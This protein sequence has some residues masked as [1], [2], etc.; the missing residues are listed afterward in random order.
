M[1]PASLDT[2]KKGSALEEFSVQAFSAKIGDAVFTGK[3]ASP[4]YA[5][6]GTLPVVVAV[7]GSGYTCDYFDIAGYSLL[8]RAA[9]RGFQVLALNRP[10]YGGSTPLADSDDLIQRNAEVINEVLDQ[11]LIKLGLGGRPVFLIGHSV[12]GAVVLTIA[13]LEPSLSIAGIAISGVGL[14]T[15]PESLQSLSQIPKQYYV[16]LPTEV[17]DAAMFGPEDSLASDMP[18]ASHV[19]DS[20][21]PLSELLDINSGWQERFPGIAARIK[22]PVHFRQAENDALWRA[23]HDGVN[24]FA[25]Y[26]NAAPLIDGAI[27]PEVGHCIDFHLAGQAFQEGQ[28]NFI[29]SLNN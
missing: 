28:L 24:E 19:A 4:N 14:E 20:P 11:L 21:A 27:I 22:V 1:W 2:N 17:K 12:G 15:P 10:G 9:A 18:A 16:E 7:H 8:A 5:C 3:I 29:A 25:H 23:A 6:N 26:L 13:S